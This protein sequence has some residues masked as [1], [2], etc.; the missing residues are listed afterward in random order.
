MLSVTEQRGLPVGGDHWRYGRIGRFRSWLGASRLLH[1]VETQDNRVNTVH[2]KSSDDFD[3]FLRFQLSTQ[4]RSL[5]MRSFEFAFE[6]L[7]IS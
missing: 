6:A 1:L 7:V 2:A 5:E 3:D 4:N